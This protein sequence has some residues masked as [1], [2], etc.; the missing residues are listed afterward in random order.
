MYK[1]TRHANTSAPYG[2]QQPLP[3]TP[4][5]ASVS[6]L[7][8]TTKVNAVC[9][10]ILADLATRKKTNLQNIITA[11]VSKMPPAIDEGLTVV[12]QLLKEDVSLAGRAVAS[13]AVEHICFLVDVNRLYDHA[14]GLYNL[15]LTMQIA[16]Q[17]QRDPREYIPFI[18]MLHEMSPIWLK[19]S[20]DEYLERHE[21]ALGHL[22][23]F[24]DFSEFL[25][26]T[27][28]H[29]LYKTALGI[30]RY[31]SQRLA[32]ITNAYAEYLETQSK[33]REAGLAYESLDNFSKATSCYQSAGVA[34]WREC[35]FAAQSQTPPLSEDVL[36]EL[37]S[38]L[39]DALLEARDYT[40]AAK[41]QLD[42]LNSVEGIRT[43]CKAYE[44]AEAMRLA[45]FLRRRDLLETAVDA[46]LGDALSSSTE[47]LADC[48]SQLKAQVPRILELRK[49]AIEDP[50]GFYEGERLGGE[51]VPDDVSIAA[52]SRLSTSASLF[53][54]YST[55]T[56]ATGKTGE[57]GGTGATQQH[58][59]RKKREEKKRARGRKG[60]VYEQE[61]LVNSVRRL[62][63][64]VERARPEVSRLVVGL[65]RRNM[66]ERARAIEG[67]MAELVESCQAAISE[68]WQP[69]QP[70]TRPQASS[71]GAAVETGNGT[72]DSANQESGE[73]SSRGV[74]APVIVAFERLS[75]LG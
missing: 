15:E 11:H 46:G 52:S 22:A 70:G 10:A 23:D 35:L 24:D 16:Q 14:L 74:G 71:A 28:K 48:R 39:V 59:N 73:L 34:C 54:R 6:T 12:A 20:I 72:Q 61:Y 27:K 67:L 41:I 75:L 38:N 69:G 1:D 17:S 56:A 65:T 53:T 3:P 31:N 32:V 2:A 4:T 8:S 18:R 62:I 43:L 19:F 21:K 33:F 66:A 49:K 63:E 44:F 45:V 36:N 9:D 5:S 25:Q 13:K 57:T 55:G 58:R 30:Y 51:D 50:L 68:V 29:H 47:L 60:T 42:Y 40:A 7:T 37:A 64:R 26:Y